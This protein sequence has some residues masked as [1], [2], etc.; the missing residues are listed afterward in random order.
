MKIDKTPRET[1]RTQYGREGERMNVMKSIGCAAFAALLLS[2]SPGFS[3]TE[4]AYTVHWGPVSDPSVSRVLV[5]RSVTSTLADFVPI[6][7]VT[8]ADTS[9]VDQGGALASDIRYYYSLRSQTAAGTLGLFSDIVSGLTISDTASETLKNQCRIDSISAI[10]SATCRVYWSTAAPSTGKVR[11]WRL[12]TT[13]VLES[14][15]TTAPALHHEMVIAGL[16]KNEIYFARAVAHDASGAS[17]T[18]SA[19]KGFTT[20]PPEPEFAI[21]TSADSVFVPENGTADLGVKL[22]ARPPATVEVT[23]VR[24]NGDTDLSIQSGSVLSFTT[25]NWDSYQT[26]TFAAANDVDVQNGSADVI[27]YVSSGASA[28]VKTVK[29]VEV[30]DDALAFVLDRSSLA[31]P[32]G[33]TAQF[34]VRLG[35]QPPSSVTALVTR[36]GGDTDITVQSGGSLTF[37]TGNWD[38]DQT[39]TLAAA[40]DA[41]VLD[42]TA[43]I[44]VRAS[45]GPTVPDAFLTATEEDGGSLYFA[46]DADTVF[47]PEAGTAAFHVRLTSQPSEDL[48]VA[49]SRSGGDTDVTVQSG[50]S[51][52]FTAGN[53]DVD[54]TV[55]LAAAADVD[56]AAGAAAILV[57]AVSGPTVPDLTLV[58]MEIDDDALFFVLDADTVLV[59]EGGTAQFRVKLGNAPP[60]SVA[61]SVSRQ[62]GDESVTVQSG[63]SL[64]FTTAN[65]NTYQ[66]V[67][68]AAGQD[69]DA[70][71]ETATIRV[72]ATSGAVV[73]DAAVF[74][75]VDDDDTG[76]HGTATASNEIKI[77]PMPYRPD[78]GALTIV[79]LPEGGSLT[80][81]DLAGRK[82]REIAWGATTDSSWNGTNAGGSGVASG[83]YFV[84]IRNAASSVVNKQAILVVR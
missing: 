29:A 20:S 70:Q 76:D 19:A 53:W 12:G 1:Y 14:A 41:D 4:N 17:L 75:R 71:D 84:V 54:Q 66:T 6:G 52:T 30:D 46:I 49:V 60:A 73:N 9:F 8:S 67:T 21:V 35:S 47:V 72:R 45:S 62:S 37:T 7:S 38:V 39:V 33:G 81:Y 16:A 83:R 31:V 23:L 43:T 32:E 27:V 79:N 48:H 22:S 3:Q 68:L 64:T 63:G 24:T 25:S 80:I 78:R 10:D 74:V 57:H 5:Y 51:L 82:V 18:I 69:D 2:A 11:Y 13:A 65:W 55:T 58:A 26:A 59:D 15:S 56:V 28:P 40:G 77:Y 50:G 34:H 36:S 61:V 44:R 42:G